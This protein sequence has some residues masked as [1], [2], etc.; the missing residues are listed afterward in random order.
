[1]ST[2]GDSFLGNGSDSL[3]VSSEALDAREWV[4]DETQLPPDSGDNVV[5]D[6]IDIPVDDD[7]EDVEDVVTDDASGGFVLPDKLKG[8]TFDEL[9]EIYLNLESHTNR[10]QNE[11]SSRIDELSEQNG[12]LQRFIT[13]ERDSAAGSISASDMD[14]ILDYTAINP[15]AAYNEALAMY[16]NGELSTDVVEAIIDE[17]YASDTSL[18]RKIDRHYL[19]FNS[20]VMLENRVGDFDNDRRVNILASE[21]SKLMG[22]NPDS[23]NY[24]AEIG[25]I[26]NEMPWLFGSFSGEDVA[27]GLN[28]AYRLAVGGDPTKSDAYKQ[29]AANSLRDMKIDSRTENGSAIDGKEAPKSEGDLIR[30]RAFGMKDPAVGLFEDF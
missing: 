16:A 15:V 24:S 2:D 12:E 17:V 27:N 23:V 29:A 20:Q 8:K 28:V 19:A 7:I 5:D 14:S 11:L 10:R 13:S 30:E 3:D 26:A 6:D 1:M 22:S 18:G 25:R 4:P 9:A 21:T